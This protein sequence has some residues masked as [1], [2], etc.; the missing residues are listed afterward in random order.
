[1]IITFGEYK[2]KPIENVPDSTLLW[3]L[4][5]I[6]YRHYTRRTNKDIFRYIENKFKDREENTNST[7][8]N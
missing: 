7:S 2:G 8:S 3:Y 4:D 6:S 5:N 1:M